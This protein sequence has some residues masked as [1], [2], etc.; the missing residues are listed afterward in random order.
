[1][2]TR[3]LIPPPTSPMPRNPIEWRKLMAAAID[4]AE[5]NGSRHLPGLRQALAS[6]QSELLL[7]R[8]GILSPTD[9]ARE[10]P[11]KTSETPR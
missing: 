11:E 2:K 8:M 5:R 10:F 1:M 9:I 6:G 3:L 4:Q 7:R